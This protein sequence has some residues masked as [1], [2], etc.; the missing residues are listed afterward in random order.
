MSNENSSDV[1]TDCPAFKCDNCNE[2]VDAVIRT[3]IVSLPRYLAVNL[4][5][6]DI[7]KVITVSLLYNAPLYNVDSFI[8]K[9]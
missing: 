5:I 9:L 2:Y 3:S 6:F 4:L 8:T 1:Q 7:E